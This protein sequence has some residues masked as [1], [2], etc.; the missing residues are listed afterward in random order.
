MGL[1]TVGLFAE[2]RSHDA[3]MTR[4]LEIFNTA[5]KQVELNY[6]DTINPDKSIKAAIEAFLMSTDPYTEYYTVDEQ[7]VLQ[8]MTTGEYGGIGSYIMQRNGG[9]YINQPIEG[10]PS[11]L[12]GLKPGDHIIRVD[13]V[14]TAKMG[15][16]KVTKLL[17]GVPGTKVRVTV[18]RPYVAD[19]ILTFEITRGKVREP[20]V[21]YSSVIG[22]T[23]FIRIASFTTS[24][25]DEIKTILEG[26]KANPAVKNIIIDLR[27]NGGGVVESAV[28][29][30]G[31]FLPKGTEVVRNV[32]REP[33]N[34]KTYKTQR[35]P[36][37]P[38]IP[39]AV[40][41]DGGTASA[42]EITAGA[43]QDLDRAVLL[44]SRSFGKGLVQA[45]MQL[46][47]GNMMKVTIAKY[48]LPSGRLIQAIDYS[49][50]NP[51]GSV[52][53]VPDSLTNVFKTANGREV[54]D[55]GGL[56][57]DTTIS[58]G[59]PTRLVYNIVTDHWAF[60]FANR[61]AAQ[62][63]QIGEAKDFVITDS[64]YADFK[65]SIDP[66]RFKYDHVCEE[67]MKQLR[68]AA[69]TEGYMNDETKAKLDEL[70]KLL[71]HNLDHDLD[72]HRKAIEEYLGPEI[73]SRYYYDRGKAEYESRDDDAIKAAIAIMSDPVKYNKILNRTKKR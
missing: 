44:G 10:S 49:H 19:S 65:R 70:Q 9:S 1:T 15:S 35:S 8:K 52:A 23:G 50:R 24:T 18:N 30:L 51:D 68:T 42:S 39:L 55:G 53:R 69:Q 11:A 60:D 27:G 31:N 25:P 64:I 57:P 37:F 20:S 26:F 36:I 32:G 29:L 66:K 45:P 4:N 54:R 38:D 41:I 40:L 56:R 16:D 63:P 43:L 46:P 21:P 2:R 3:A 12:A 61:Y 67:L 47:Y 62:H 58:W 73:L 59:E 14:E 7:E 6:V 33:S 72:T 34:S 13:S 28:E 48:Y 71:T 5:V 17:K 22:N